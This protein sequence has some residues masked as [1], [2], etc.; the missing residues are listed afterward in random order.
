MTQPTLAQKQL[1]IQ[2][3]LAKREL[4]RRSL[5]QFTRQTLPSYTPG[6]VH[7]D[8]TQRLEKFSRDV[9]AKKSPRLMLL[10]PPR[11]GKSELASTPKITPTAPTGAESEG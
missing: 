1:L 10:M 7:H 8:I 6:W 11:H 5:L 2:A 9:I 4:A 3:Q